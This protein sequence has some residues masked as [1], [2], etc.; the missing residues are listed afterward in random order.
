MTRI[1][2]VSNICA[3]AFRG[4]QRMLGMRVR[5]HARVHAKHINAT[6]HCWHMSPSQDI[7]P[8]DTEAG[9]RIETLYPGASPETVDVAVIEQRMRTYTVEAELLSTATYKQ[10]Q[11]WN[12]L[13]ILGALANFAWRV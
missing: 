12:C 10:K 13:S 3:T 2:A 7:L 8:Q 5:T 1:S 6:K 9:I 11:A 4:T